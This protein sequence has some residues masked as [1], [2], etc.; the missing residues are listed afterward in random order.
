MV[1]LI[2]FGNAHDTFDTFVLQ[3][4]KR[5]VL[6]PVCKRAVSQL[7][8]SMFLYV[9]S[10]LFRVALMILESGQI[11]FQ[12]NN[13]HTEMLSNRCRLIASGIQPTDS[14]YLF[15]ITHS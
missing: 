11:R 2:F 13:G 12:I 3:Y 14:N 8:G 7:G 15:F 9:C 6:I 5:T 4:P 10:I 1:I